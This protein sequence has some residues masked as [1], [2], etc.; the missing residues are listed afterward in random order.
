MREDTLEEIQFYIQEFLRHLCLENNLKQKFVERNPDLESIFNLMSKRE[1]D[2]TAD[3]L[4]SFFLD[5]E[6]SVAYYHIK[7]LVRMINKGKDDFFDLRDFCCFMDFYKL[8]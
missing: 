7:A 1:R 3:E 8:N 6:I 5:R 4:R 2:V